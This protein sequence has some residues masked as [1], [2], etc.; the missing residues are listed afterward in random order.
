LNKKDSVS[1]NIHSNDLL[2]FG[3]NGNI[4][5]PNEMRLKEI[6]AKIQKDIEVLNYAFKLTLQEN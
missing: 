4:F 5:T 6:S 3:D 2:G 1:K